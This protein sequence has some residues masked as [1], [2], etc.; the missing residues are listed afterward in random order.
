MRTGRLLLV[1]LL[2][3]ISVIGCS[4]GQGKDTKSPEQVAELFVQ[5]LIA[6]DVDEAKT[7]CTDPRIVD[8]LQQH[9]TS[10]H[11]I[12]NYYT[13]T[14]KNVTDESAVFG[15]DENQAVV[16]VISDNGV[17]WFKI[18]FENISSEWKIVWVI[19]PCCG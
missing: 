14:Y 17:I 16:D 10:L 4:D 2:I 6:V 5:S 3:V 7:Y 18:V 11:D 8:S 9:L 15:S 19:A 12:I 1:L 13:F